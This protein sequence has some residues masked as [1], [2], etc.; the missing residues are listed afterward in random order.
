MSN[1]QTGQPLYLLGHL[2]EMNSDV[3]LDTMR[4]FREFKMILVELF[5]DA[6]VGCFTNPSLAS[7]VSCD[8]YR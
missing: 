3:P 4:G 2:P 5:D 6:V 1:S 7:L 8:E